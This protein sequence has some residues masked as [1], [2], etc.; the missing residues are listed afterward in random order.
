M[1]KHF[2]TQDIALSKLVLH[3]RNVRARSE[4]D[5]LSELA[6]NIKAHGLLQPLVV[7]ALGGGRFGVLAGGRRLAALSLLAEDQSAKGFSA[8]MN[9]PCWIVPEGADISSLSFA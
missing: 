3:P 4:H 7:E 8:K 9:A 6:S 1:T 2:E 5:E